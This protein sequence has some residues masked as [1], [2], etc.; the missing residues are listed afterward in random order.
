MISNTLIKMVFLSAVDMRD[1]F[2]LSSLSNLLLLLLF[3]LSVLLMFSSFFLIAISTSSIILVALS[4]FLCSMYLSIFFFTVEI[5][6]SSMY[7]SGSFLC[8]LCY[9]NSVTI[10]SIYIYVSLFYITY[11]HLSFLLSLITIF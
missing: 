6:F 7:P 8:C 9:L 1:V 4:C 11:L 2:F 5:Y 3:F 10:T